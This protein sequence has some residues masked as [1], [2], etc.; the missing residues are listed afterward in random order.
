MTVLGT[1]GKEKSD[2]FELAK[3]QEKDVI[4]HCEKHGDIKTKIY[5]FKGIE[6]KANCQ[7]CE[8]EAQEK[9]RLLEEER[10]KEREREER[11]TLENVESEYWEKTIDDLKP[12]TDTQKKAIDSVK[13]L[14]ENRTGKI[15]LIGGNGIGKTHLGSMAVKML[16]GF[17]YSMYEITTLIRQ[18]YTSKAVKTELEIVSELASCPMLVIDELGRT[19]G[20]EAE[21]NWLSYILDKRHTRKLPFMLLSNKH[22]SRDCPNGDKCCDKCFEKFVDNDVLSRLREDTKIIT[23]VAPDHRAMRGN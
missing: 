14:I 21:M 10:A 4:F 6:H 1:D 16:G 18:S 5:I 2:F 7:L 3:M 17:I 12:Y 22:L 8:K 13:K 15:V 11:Y 19:K 9:Q 20:S 23:V